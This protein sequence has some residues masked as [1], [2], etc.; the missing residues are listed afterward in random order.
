MTT[1]FG[2]GTACP[3]SLFV[4]NL[5]LGVK[6]CDFCKFEERPRGTGSNTPLCLCRLH[7]KASISPPS[8]SS[9]VASA[10]AALLNCT[11]PLLEEHPA[12]IITSISLMNMF[13]V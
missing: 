7:C 11:F 2:A 12:H 8:A 9:C 10:A 6:C 4:I 5:C 13:C 1:T 3:Q